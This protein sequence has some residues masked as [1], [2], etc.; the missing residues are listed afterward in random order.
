MSHALPGPGSLST[1][2]EQTVSSSRCRE[3]PHGAAFPSRCNVR[4]SAA[5]P[6]EGVAIGRCL[7]PMRSVGIKV[8]KRKLREHVSLAASGETILMTDRDQ[9]VAELG[10]P[11]ETRSPTRVD[12]DL[13]EAVGSGMLTPPRPAISGP[14]PRPRPSPCSTKSW[15]SRPRLSLQSALILGHLPALQ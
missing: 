7:V 6:V 11:W 14:P 15:P 13:A 12:T 2:V 10:R 1:R 8:L 9:V 5:C 3:L 4:A